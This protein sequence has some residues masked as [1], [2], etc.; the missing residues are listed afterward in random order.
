VREQLGGQRHRFLHILLLGGG[1]DQR[2][3]IQQHAHFPALKMGSSGASS[4]ASAYWRGMP[5]PSNGM[6]EGRSTVPVSALC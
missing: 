3:D 2:A 4:G 1:T 5:D 6:L